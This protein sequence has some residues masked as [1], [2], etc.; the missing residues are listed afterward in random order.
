MRTGALRPPAFETFPRPAAAEAHR[1]MEAGD[2][3]GRAP[4]VAGT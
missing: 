1:R 3:T 2:L 4:L